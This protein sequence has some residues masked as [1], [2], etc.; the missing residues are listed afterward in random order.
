M[1]NQIVRRLIAAGA[2]PQK[3]NQFAM[4]FQKTLPGAN[5][6]PTDVDDAFDLQ[7][8]A[9]SR[10]MFPDAFRPPT[11]LDEGFED[12]FNF[13]YPGK[14]ETLKVRAFDTTAPGYSLAKKNGTQ[15]EQWIIKNI[16]L[17]AS[18]G[19]LQ[20]TLLDPNFEKNFPGFLGQLKPEEG[21]KLASTYL[22]EYNNANENFLK[23]TE[24]FLNKDQNY[25]YGLPDPKLTYGYST[26][27]K[28]GTIG[29]DT[30]PGVKDYF[31]KA[32][33]SFRDDPNRAGASQAGGIAIDAIVKKVAGKGLTPNKDEQQR[34]FN[35]KYQK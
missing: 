5:L 24:T 8:D 20:D 33:A 13:V 3:A 1:A 15:L 10:A 21:I 4:Q 28:K 9:A 14:S 26:N 22:T 27:L 34:R 2:S 18:L 32:N 11:Y 30:I 19:Y 25:K 12:Y 16:D 31:T 7:L 23:T 6:K 35:L 29:V 17:G